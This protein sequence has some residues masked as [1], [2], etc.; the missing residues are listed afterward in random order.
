MRGASPRSTPSASSSRRCRGRALAAETWGFIPAR[1]GSKSIP[2]KNL[3]PL[4]GRPLIEY[5]IGAGRAS[6]RLSRLVC[7][8][9]HDGIAAACTAL[10]VRVHPRPA[11]L[12]TDEAALL[13]VLRYVLDD[14]VR[15]EGRV[16]EFLA[17]LQPTSPFVSPE[18]I[19]ACVT[20]LEGDPAADSAQTIAPLPHNHHA[21]NQRV[22]ED[23][24]V[25]F[26]FPDERARF[27]NKQTK[28]VHHVFGNLVVARTASLLAGGSVFGERSVGFV[29]PAVSAMDVDGPEDLDLAEWLLQSGRVRLPWMASTQPR[30]GR[31]GR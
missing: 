4:G 7:S 24:R 10:D 23:G 30:G 19:D 25:R 15:R 29:I 31:K 21:F 12:A 1:G 13:D 11:A 18:E 28:P 9:D 3:T 20:L 6:T 26:R 14:V 17:I 2:L 5:V 22:F 27:Y 8:T 16:A